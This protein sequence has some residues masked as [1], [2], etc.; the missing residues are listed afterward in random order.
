VRRKRVQNAR[1]NQ[2][3]AG[4]VNVGDQVDD[5]FVADFAD[6]VDAIA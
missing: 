1:Q 2:L 4:E 5:A 6:R 3:L